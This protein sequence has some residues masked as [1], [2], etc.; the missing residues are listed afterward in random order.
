MFRIIFIL[1]IS[2][3]YIFGGNHPNVIIIQTDEHNLRTLG[4]YRK[5]MSE[6]QAFIWGK[7]VMVE[8]PHIDSLA[9]DGLICT[10]YFAASSLYTVTGFMGLRSLSTGNR[11]T[12]Q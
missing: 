3:G 8:T 7:D 5:H 2:F 6:D 12:E 10:N 11:F 1:L 4:C 9:E